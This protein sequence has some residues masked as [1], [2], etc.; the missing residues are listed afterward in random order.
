MKYLEIK[1]QI[2]EL[3][4]AI[5]NIQLEKN[6][7][8]RQ[9]RYKQACEL[10]QKERE[11]IR[12][13]DEKKDE[14]LQQLEAFKTIFSSME[15]MHLLL[16]IL[17]EFNQDEMIQT[18]SSIKKE[19]IERMKSEY[20]ELWNERRQLMQEYRFTEAYKLQTQLIAIGEFLVKNS[21]N[22]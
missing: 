13:L 16:N 8:I 12:E 6:E 1:K 17:L 21:R 14:V 4:L 10:R 19:F 5:V 3:K 9:Q 7:I 15:E 22:I 2:L 11:L 20:E 18:Y